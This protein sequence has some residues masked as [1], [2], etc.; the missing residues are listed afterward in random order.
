MQHRLNV[1]AM[2]GIGAAS[3]GLALLAAACG[4]GSDGGDSAQT[5]AA[6]TTTG[7]TAASATATGNAAASG[8]ASA[9]SSASSTSSAAAT[10]PTAT[11]EPPDPSHGTKNRAVEKVAAA[12]AAQVVVTGVGTQDVNKQEAFGFQFT[13]GIPGY[14]VEYVDKVTTCGSGADVD[15]HGAKGI[16]LVTLKPAIAHDSSGATTVTINQLQSSGKVITGIQQ[17]CDFEGVVQF[18]VGL[19]GTGAFQVLEGNNGDQLAVL[20]NQKN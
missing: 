19:T 15:M 2:L 1:R 12:N 16:L 18:A 4:G 20:V 7:T 10:T 14:R 17:I 5:A 8:T 9:S 3:L 6:T 13:A 11:K